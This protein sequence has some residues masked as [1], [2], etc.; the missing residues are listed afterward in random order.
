MSDNENVV[1]PTKPAT[2]D[3]PLEETLTSNA[4]HNI[5]P[6]RY[7]KKNADG[8][9]VEEQEEL[10]ERVAQNVALAEAV[11]ADADLAF[12]PRHVKRDHPKREEII[13]EEFDNYTRMLLTEDNIVYA[14]Y[15]RFV[16]DLPTEI[17][18]KVRTTAEE[19]RN[20]MENLQFVPNTP[21]LVNAGDDL[22]ML[23]ACFVLHPS[24]DMGEIH[25]TAK[26]AALTFQSGGGVGYP[27]SQLR[28]Y[29]DTVGSTG[30]VASGPL[31]FMRTFDQMCST[32][33]AAGMRRGAQMGV[34]RVTHPDVIQF[35][36]AKNKDV[37]LARTLK[38]NDPDDPTY[39]SFGEA[40]EEAREL[41]DE[42]GKVPKHLRNAVE[43]HLSNF[44]ISVGMTDDF[45][46]AVKEGE[47]HTFINPRTGDPHIATEQTKEMYEW[48]GLGKYVEVG[49]PLSIPAEELWEDIVEGA[50]ENGEP[51]VVYLDQINRDH[52]FPTRSSP[53]GRGGQYEVQ[54]TNPSLGA[55]TKVLT[56]DGIYPIEEL[57]GQEI[58]V[59]TLEGEWAKGECFLSG[60]GETVYEV[61]IENEKTYRAT[62]E[63]EW[64]VLNDDPV[65]SHESGQVEY[66]GYEKTETDELEEGDRIPLTQLDSLKCG[67]RGDREDGFLIGWLYGDGWV[68]IRSDKA[69][70]RQFGFGFSEE[71]Q[72]NGIMEKILD[73]VENIT[74]FR[75][76]PS[77]TN[78]GGEDWAQFD[79]ANKEINDYMDSFNVCKKEDGLPDLFW[80]ECS[81]SFRRGFIDG[82][83]SSDGHVSNQDNRSGITSAHD[84]LVS[85]F[86]DL[87]GFYGLKHSIRDRTDT[88]GSEEYESKIINLSTIPSDQFNAKFD[89]THERK[90]QELDELPEPQR[91]NV[92][93]R[94][95]TIE[96]VT[97][98][99]GGEDV[100]DITVHHPSH[101]FRLS[102]CVTGNCGEQPLM[103]NDACNLGHINLST[104]VDDNRTLWDEYDGNGELEERVESFLEEAID[105]EDMDNRIH[106]GTRFLDNV[107]TMNDFPTEDISEVV[108]RTR[109]IGLGIMGLAQ[110]YIQLGVEYGSEVGNEVARQ[111]MV[112]IN[113]ESKQAS[114]EL[115]VERQSFAAWPD[116]KY[117]YPRKHSEWFER[118]TGEK[119]IDW[120]EGFPIRNYDTTTIAP[121]GTTGMVGNTTGGC[122]PI[123]NVAY[124]KNVSDD[125]QGDEM[126]VE[127]DDYFLRVL[128][129]NDIDVEEV[130][131][132]A[133]EQMATNDFDGVEGLSAVPK[134][135][136]ELFVTAGE[137]SGLE[138]ASVQCAL[139]EGVGS[140][141]SKSVNA[142]HESTLKDAKEAF[143]Y[144][145]ENDGKGVTYYRQ[146]TRSKQVLTTDG[147]S[148]EEDE[149]SVEV[150]SESENPCPECGEGVME[151]REGCSLCI[152]CGFSP[153][154]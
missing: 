37:S 114:K 33:A 145:Y 52:A 82:L 106:I 81:E 151:Q 109:K 70:P 111:V 104:V 58:Q 11:H 41:I 107:I 125:V 113:Q 144:I 141:I 127:F 128:E 23:S 43:G 64:P 13:D 83:F 118:Q 120:Q 18:E 59:P 63:H 94:H 22:Q 42:D 129:A 135:I 96:S 16:S 44:N 121:T 76:T 149:K 140:A 35:I 95:S 46:E 72:E 39:T 117:A 73:K 75:Y 79:A 74:G 92:N 1:L 50:Y 30:G 112:H 97:K 3:E 61:E 60:E 132:E 84:E 7:L 93:S 91:R 14:D 27:F 80:E 131:D 99:E 2:V 124:H 38:L 101:T 90:Q 115:S 88:L 68:T 24:D 62:E 19:F 133:K 143:E 152:S 110:M 130:K 146:G 98:R 100:W 153:C 17:E 122:E 15:E 123:Y 86:S 49:E 103:E 66:N 108:G 25:D 142:S 87:L 6:A 69:S 48:H 116:S 4:Y 53:T 136:G 78:D 147:S 29:G 134:R 150:D 54:A 154:Q 56:S 45:M 26:Q 21:T 89:I 102:H 9:L 40:L 8:E 5:L 138:H 10:F 139:Q 105:W 148:D 119:A 67:N 57:E 36:H 32:V 51:G 137:L 71:N 34:M 65:W 47:E 31:S 12:S 20:L 85:D 77:V 126:L 55:E 28:P